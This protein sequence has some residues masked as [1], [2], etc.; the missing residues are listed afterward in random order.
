MRILDTSFKSNGFPNTS[1]YKIDGPITEDDVR[2]LNSITHKVI[3][4]CHNTKELSP[5]ILRRINNPNIQISVMGGLDYY[6]KKKFN[7]SN[8]ISRT[9]HS[10]NQLATIIEYFQKIENKMRYTW[11]DRQKVMFIYKSLCEALHYTRDD[12]SDFENG[13]DISRS[14]SGLLY[15]RL[16]CSGFALVFKEAMDRIGVPC[17]YQNRS[18]SHSWDII[19]LDG[20]KYGIELT[21]ECSNKKAD[22]I[23]RFGYFGM[24]PNFY[25][26]RHHNLSQ[27]EE[28]TEYPLSTFNVEELQQDYKM[29]AYGKPVEKREMSPVVDGD[30]K[31]FYNMIKMNPDGVYDYIIFIHG[32]TLMIH[33]K[34]DPNSLT[35]LDIFHAIDNKGWDPSIGKSGTSSIVTYQRDDQSKFFVQKAKDL[36]GRVSEYYYFDVKMKNGTPVIRRATLLSEMKLDQDWKEP[37]RNIVANGLLSS[38]RLKR[39]IEQTRGYVG[40]IGGDHCLY[41]DRDFEKDQ[42]HLIEHAL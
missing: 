13:E 17:I 7:A 31:V 2:T 16:V 4:V 22:N 33:T 21:W 36:D 15:G 26:N 14:L 23:C 6:H 37:I 42:L 18:H 35:M 3:V 19:E 38:S 20:K 24:D 34:K 1:F 30:H 32:D 11:T 40:Y 29:I 12:E 25:K 27:E 41:Y 10:P 8:Y 5:S 28:E 9:L 39:K